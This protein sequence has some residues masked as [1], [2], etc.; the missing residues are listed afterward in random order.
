M[1]TI[2]P[3]VRSEPVRAESLLFCTLIFSS[4]IICSST[5]SD[6]TLIRLI[7]HD[8]TSNELYISLYRT[9]ILLRREI[10]MSNATRTTT[11]VQCCTLYT[12]HC[13]T[14]C[15]VLY[16]HPLSPVHH[17]IALHCTLFSSLRWRNLFLFNQISSAQM[18]IRVQYIQ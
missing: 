17:C 13:G 1:F 2:R 15:T 6:E 8:V 4:V 10:L 11:T 12:V 5:V 3:P 9:V 16:Y 14:V 18:H 7:P